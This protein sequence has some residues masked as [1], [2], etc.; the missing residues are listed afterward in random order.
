MQHLLIGIGKVH[1]LCRSTCKC[2]VCAVGH[3]GGDG[4]FVQQVQ[5]AVCAGEH[6]RQAG[7]KV[8]QRHHR[9]KGAEGRKG[10]H[11]YAL[12][13]HF[14]ALVKVQAHTQH[15][16]HREQ[17]QGVRDGHGQALA[18]FHRLLLFAQHLTVGR[19][20][21]GAGCGVLI[22]QGVLQAAQA[23]QHIAVGIGQCLTVLPG[24]TVAALCA[25]HRQGHAH[26]QI[27]RQQ[28][29][30][31][32][33]V[34][35]AHK[36]RHA[37][38]ADARDADGRNGVGVEHLQRLDVGRDERDQ[39][40]AVTAFQ[41]CR[42]QTAQGT[43]H[44]IADQGQQL[45][46]DIVVGCLLC[47]TQN[48]AQQR[49]HQNAGKGRA[50]GPHRACKPQRTQDAK[51]AEDRNEG[52]A[53]V[54]CHPHHDRC[55]HNGQ[56]GLYQYDQP[57]HNGKGAAAIDFIHI[58]HPPLPV[59]PAAAVPDTGGCK[60]PALPAARRGCPARSH[61][62]CSLHRCSRCAPRLPDGGRSG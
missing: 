50:H 10:A 37:D 1:M 57:S 41:L 7:T 56:H 53:E 47:V 11:Q 19:D 51:A 62:H 18:V 42:G 48:A 45:E 24:G 49:K 54:A 52:G 15:G 43:E 28:H 8:C 46:G 44:L 22:L 5:H 29:Q 55:Q 13:A 3:I 40:A 61:G 38:D 14:T 33:D 26:Q 59:F 30:R 31:R 16:Q 4:L 39:V 12:H 35:A 60:P 58:R 36:A 17:D 20:A 6:L 21:L 9:A 34:P 25:P 2:G 23:F 27:A 32:Q